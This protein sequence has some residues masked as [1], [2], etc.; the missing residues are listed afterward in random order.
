LWLYNQY[1]MTI[2]NE[3]ASLMENLNASIA[4]YRYIRLTASN[5]TKKS[6]NNVT[7]HIRSII[8]YGKD[9]AETQEYIDIDIIQETQNTRDIL[10]ISDGVPITNEDREKAGMMLAMLPPD[11]LHSTIKSFRVPSSTDPALL[12]EAVTDASNELKTP[13][14]KTDIDS[15]LRTKDIMVETRLMTCDSLLWKPIVNISLNLLKPGIS[16]IYPY[17][18][19]DNKCIEFQYKIALSE[20][21]R[22][23][24]VILLL[25]FVL[26]ITLIICLVCQ[27]RM[28]LDY[29]RLDSVRNNFVYTMIHELKRP[30]STLKMCMSVLS[31]RKMMENE[32]TKA[33]I[34]EKCRGAVNNLSTYFSRLRDITFN[35]ASQIPLGIESCNVLQLVE[36][37]IGKTDVP[38]SK[39]VEFHIECDGD[40]QIAC[41]PLHM[42]QMIGNLI[43][44]AVKYSEER[45]NIMI[46][47]NKNPDSIALSVEDNGIGISETDMSKVFNKFYR[48]EAAM[49]SG[50]PG[51]GLGLAYV[52]LLA[53]AHGGSVSVESHNN[54]QHY[55]AKR[56]H[57]NGK[58]K[59]SVDRFTEIIGFSL[60][61][62]WH[63]P[64]RAL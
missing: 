47:A 8:N 28:I 30:L 34:L 24:G 52:R 15:I 43:E 17:S 35:E 29:A 41:D 40:M 25:S 27:I 62:P 44:N 60:Y 6:D 37:V 46:K 13:F 45:V 63:I 54:H 5:K 19:L 22:A 58:F 64:S 39:K 21:M 33:S 11:S 16:V 18:P 7:S 31:N 49:R 50:A 36:D 2:D 9:N 26:S 20:I 1:R 53:E 4:D 51:V 61:Y 23:M 14:T 12:Y 57:D 3:K 48:S 10:N 56:I 32:E 38:S 59:K 55:K 42:S